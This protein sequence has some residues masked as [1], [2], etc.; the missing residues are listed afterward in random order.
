MIDRQRWRGNVGDRSVAEILSGCD[1]D[2]EDIADTLKI[3]VERR[4]ADLIELLLD[5]VNRA[6]T[7]GN[8]SRARSALPR[9]LTGGLFM[10]MTAMPSRTASWA[11]SVMRTGLR[12]ERKF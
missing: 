10:V 7:R 8:S 6:L 1:S 4:L 3:A 11:T 2:R 5:C 9:P 12:E